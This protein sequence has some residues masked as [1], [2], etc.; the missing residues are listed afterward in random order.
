[1]AELRAND[2]RWAIALGCM[3][4]AYAVGQA[5][6][7]RFGFDDPVEYVSK[8]AVGVGDAK[9]SMYQDHLA[10]RKSELDAINGQVPVLG[11]RLGIATPYNGTLSAVLRAREAAWGV[12]G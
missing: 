12:A 11:A 2:E 8:F 3:A 5:L 4:E 7:I 6:G 10:K 1:V 9:P